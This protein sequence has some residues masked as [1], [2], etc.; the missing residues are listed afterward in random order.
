MTLLKQ[1]RTD[2]EGALSYFT[3]GNENYPEG[4]GFAIKPWITVRW[5]NSGAKI[6]GN[7]AIVMGN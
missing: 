5:E 3:C 2:F 1:F 6:Y 7:A 4:H